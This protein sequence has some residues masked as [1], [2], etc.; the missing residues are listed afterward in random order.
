MADMD[1]YLPVMVA[2]DE[3]G[4]ITEAAVDFDGAPWMYV[5]KEPNV[6]NHTADE[7]QQDEEGTPAGIAGAQAV[8]F[9][10]WALGRHVNFG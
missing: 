3:V 8:E 10:K 1:V 4:N 2:V 7:W 5:D 6:W 9:L